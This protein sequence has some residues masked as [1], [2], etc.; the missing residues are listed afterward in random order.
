M[1]SYNK[2]EQ[3]KETYRRQL[4]EPDASW[5]RNVRTAV[6]FIIAHLFDLRL[7][8]GW[9]KEQCGINSKIFHSKFKLCVG[10]TPKPYSLHHRI[11]V[12]KLI[13]RQT[14]DTVTDIAHSVGF[15]S[16]SSF[17]KTFK[18]RTGLTPS[19]WRNKNNGG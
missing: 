7:T 9:M 16:L 5:P 19:A 2:R 3:I 13:L 11:E 6:T 15:D 8:V 10:L 4:P 12:S 18:D 17:D 14:D 1:N